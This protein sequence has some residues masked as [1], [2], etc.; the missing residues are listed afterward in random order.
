MSDAMLQIANLVKQF[1][2]G[3][4]H[5]GHLAIDNVDIEVEAGEFFTLLGPS[6]CGKTTTLRSV[7]GLETPT[8]G[9][10]AIDGSV[11]FEN[12]HAVPVHK[13]DISMVFQSYAIWPH[14][15]VAQNVAFP[16][17]QR[18]MKSHEVNAEVDRALEMVDLGGLG[19][20]PATAL[21]GG[22]QQRVA[23]ARAIVK[24]SKL[25]LLD[26]PLSNLDAALRV[27]MRAELRSIQERLGTTTIYVTHD[28]DE[29]LALSDRIAVMRAG[30]VV[31]IG[32]PEQ[33]Y[34]RPNHEFTARF[35]GRAQLWN[36]EPTE[37]RAVVETAHG[38]LAVS[39]SLSRVGDQLLIRP[40]HVKVLASRESADR[41]VLTGE[42]RS[43][44]FSGS[45]TD[46][47]VE[48]P[49]GLVRVQEISTEHRSVG[50][51]VQL[52]LPPERC[53][54]VESEKSSTEEEL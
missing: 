22:Q 48:C 36:A 47:D 9:S 30:R 54:L 38:K 32:E 13:R 15:T 19:N 2:G 35:I 12:G 50:D 40:E 41:N 24:Q 7:A 39:D 31:E 46:L 14:M 43:V 34:L 17:E 33:L 10:I 1:E 3:R 4:Q 52:H 25:V 37:D 8:S 21:S 27:Q 29:A 49:G 53:I 23:F 11:V 44:V 42:V 20:R 6:G 5:H 18:S 26:E 28:Q 16:L 51:A 45:T